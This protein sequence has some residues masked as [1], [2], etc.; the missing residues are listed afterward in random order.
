MYVEGS[1]LDVDVLSDD[2]GRRPERRD[3]PRG[4]GRTGANRDADRLSDG[5]GR[6]RSVE[7]LKPGKAPSHALDVKFH[8][9]PS[10]ATSYAPAP[11]A[12]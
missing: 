12:E 4:V 11:V 6:N 5:A 7:R 9:H 8:S 2:R 10:T 3:R 1:K